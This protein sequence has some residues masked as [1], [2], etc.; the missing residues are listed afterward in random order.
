MSSPT[1]LLSL[2][3]YTEFAASAAKSIADVSAV[4]FLAAAASISLAILKTIEVKKPLLHARRRILTEQRAKTT[5]EQHVRILENIH[6]L[7]CSII[8]VH[9]ASGTLALHS[10]ALSYEIGKITK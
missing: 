3:R 1:R 10:P 2:L 6:H 5:K 8:Q 9:S 7:L 4:P